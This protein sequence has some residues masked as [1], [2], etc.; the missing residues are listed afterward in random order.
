ML[1]IE[2]H[3]L[4]RRLEYLQTECPIA[5]W[6]KGRGGITCCLSIEQESLLKSLRTILVK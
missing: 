4:R 6:L 1:L 2:G 3:L 5:S